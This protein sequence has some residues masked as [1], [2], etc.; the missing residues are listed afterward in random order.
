MRCPTI[1]VTMRL[2]VYITSP[3]GISYFQPSMIAVFDNINKC[4]ISLE[5]LLSG[6]YVLYCNSIYL[7]IY[8]RLN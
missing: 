3:E 5:K 1:V 6:T 7:I 4:Y 2:A 8:N